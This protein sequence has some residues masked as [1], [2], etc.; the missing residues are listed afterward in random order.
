[1]ALPLQNALKT[2]PECHQSAL[3]QVAACLFALRQPA[4]SCLQQLCCAALAGLLAEVR[5][6][7]DSEE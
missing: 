5:K 4:A 3:A 1:M 6:E 2:G 7:A